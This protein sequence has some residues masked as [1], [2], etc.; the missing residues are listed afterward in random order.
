MSTI[1]IIDD[2]DN[3][4]VNHNVD[5]AN[6]NETSRLD[7]SFSDFD[8]PLADFIEH[9]EQQRP[10][11][12]FTRKKQ[13]DKSRKCH[14]QD[15]S[16]DISPVK[17]TRVAVQ[18]PAKKG[19]IHKWIPSAAKTTAIV[20][21]TQSTV[22]TPDPPMTEDGIEQP[23]ITAYNMKPT[24]VSQIF[25]PSEK[26]V[27][28]SHPHVSDDKETVPETVPNKAAGTNVHLH[29]EYYHADGASEFDKVR[30]I[31]SQE[32]EGGVQGLEVDGFTSV[33]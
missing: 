29:N 12:P 25:C 23:K 15:I 17:P 14:D 26:S 31:L 1:V 5:M 18:H 4:D 27:A 7:D 11:E 8:D 33:Y 9:F 6:R 10:F 19:R 13:P 2:N 30:V 28:V 24:F 32:C 22:D 21:D 16:H 20:E 3:V